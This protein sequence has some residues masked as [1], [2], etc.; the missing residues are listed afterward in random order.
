MDPPSQDPPTAFKSF[1]ILMLSNILFV[2]ASTAYLAAAIVDY[3]VQEK[4]AFQGVSLSWI[5]L[6]TGA[7]CFIFVGLLDFYN[8]GLKLHIFLTL[9]GLFG[10]ISAATSSSNLKASLVCNLISTH[11]FLL[12]SLN[13]IY[14]HMRQDLKQNDSRR[15]SLWLAEFADFMFFLGEYRVQQN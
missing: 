11:L 13:W 12:E 4:A 2:T 6:C 7:V 8:T 15:T 10:T 3:Q 1:K 14:N 9:A 5:G